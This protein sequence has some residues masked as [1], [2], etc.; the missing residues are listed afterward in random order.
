M[1]GHAA[2]AGCPSSCEGARRPARTAP[3]DVVWFV[4]GLLSAS[5]APIGPL[6]TV[7]GGRG[8]SVVHLE[9]ASSRFIAVFRSEP[10]IREANYQRSVHYPAAVLAI[11]AIG[12]VCVYQVL[13]CGCTRGRVFGACTRVWFGALRGSS[14]NAGLISRQP[15]SH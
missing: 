4:Q 6:G 14:S 1:R 11:G 10:A 15:G 7:K 3:Y 8:I 12:A 5:G 9:G 13:T 2:L